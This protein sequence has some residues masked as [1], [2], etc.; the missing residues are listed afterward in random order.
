MRY[1]KTISKVKNINRNVTA[2]AKDLERPEIEQ[3]LRRVEELRKEVY[4][5]V[6]QKGKIDDEVLEASIR[7][8]HELVRYY[9]LLKEN[10]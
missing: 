3:V 2:G 9:H 8:D 10:E 4:E 7:L 5:L 6:A 1:I